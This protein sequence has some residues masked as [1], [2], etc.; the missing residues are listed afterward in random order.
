[1][2]DSA[3]LV[4]EYACGEQGAC[5]LYDSDIFRTFF[6]GMLIYKFNLKNQTNKNK[7]IIYF[8]YYCAGT[9]GGILLLAFIVDLVVW[10]KAGSINFSD[11]P[12]A[13]EAGSVEEMEN[14]KSQEAQVV[15]NNYL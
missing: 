4:W 15:E 6:H 12:T 3:C 10:Y 5:W 8:H 1:M 9:T 13:G 7:S 2:V 11:E 14:L